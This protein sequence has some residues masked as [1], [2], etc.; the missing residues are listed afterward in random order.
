MLAVS[1][2]WHGISII[3]YMKSMALKGLKWILKKQGVICGLDSSGR[4]EDPMVG[5]CK[6]GNEPIGSDIIV[7]FL[8]SSVTISF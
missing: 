7:E 8:G 5:F 3:Y 4:G 2:K 1:G 6:H